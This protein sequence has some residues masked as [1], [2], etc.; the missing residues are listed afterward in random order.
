MSG[1]SVV[2]NGSI[3]EPAVAVVV[4]AVVAAADWPADVAT[5]GAL[6]AP[7][8]PPV[9]PSA[10]VPLPPVPAAREAASAGM[11]LPNWVAAPA[12]PAP[13]LSTQHPQ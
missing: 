12:L 9:P 8:P 11:P 5:R 4:V 1:R 7:G 2:S 3:P 13:R 6:L 10:G